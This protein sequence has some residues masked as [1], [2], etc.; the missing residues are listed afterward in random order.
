[1]LMPFDLTHPNPPGL[2][3]CREGEA[4]V[5]TPRRAPEGLAPA[6]RVAASFANA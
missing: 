1:M 6:V 3:S 5:F 2:S 4:I